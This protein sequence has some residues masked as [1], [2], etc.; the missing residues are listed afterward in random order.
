MYAIYCRLHGND[1]MFVES[2]LI[3]REVHVKWVDEL[4]LQQ[5]NDVCEGCKATKTREV[6]ALV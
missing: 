6:E 3:W 2:K 5:S 1:E 4:R